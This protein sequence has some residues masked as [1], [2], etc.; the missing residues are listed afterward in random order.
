MSY[1][2]LAYY[3][4]DLMQDV[5]YENWFH[6][7][8]ENCKKFNLDKNIEILDLGCG[9][10]IFISLLLEKNYENVYGFD[11]SDEMLSVA[12]ERLEEQGH[13]AMLFQGD[14]TDFQLEK[15]F[16][17]ITIFCDGLNYLSNDDDVIKTFNQVKKHLRPGGLLMFDVHS[18]HKISTAFNNKTYSTVEDDYALIWATFNGETEYSVEHEL[19]FF[20][21]NEEGSFDKYTEFQKQRTFPIEKYKQ[22]LK[23]ENFSEIEFLGDFSKENEISTS[24]RIL[25]CAQYCG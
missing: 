11:L 12:Y 25:F 20:I 1:E 2:V 22:W 5:E 17:V 7:F 13:N 21:Q 4:D 19:T 3:Y 6:F 14:M 24:E 10:G 16:D 23:D 18:I 9:T 8:G 15:Q